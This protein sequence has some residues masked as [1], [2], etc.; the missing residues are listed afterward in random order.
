MDIE[1]LDTILWEAARIVLPE[2]DV[3]NRS[4]IAGLKRGTN[5]AELEKMVPDFRKRLI[6]STMMVSAVISELC[7]SGETQLKPGEHAEIKNT[8]DSVLARAANPRGR[9]R[10][11][12]K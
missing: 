5:P 6:G 12:R 8:V 11:A 7:A 10:K 3:M 4:M 9:S 2:L 1:H